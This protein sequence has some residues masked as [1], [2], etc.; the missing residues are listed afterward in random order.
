[1]LLTLAVS[2]FGSRALA[3]TQPP[4]V[5]AQLTSITVADQ[6]NE[7]RLTFSPLT[8][9]YSVVK[10]NST[11]TALGFALSSRATSTSLPRH[12]AG[13]L[14]SMSIEQQDT[15]LIVRFF[16]DDAIKL[17]PVSAGQNTVVV[18]FQSITGAPR[19]AVVASVAAPPP[20]Q[21]YIE[22]K[23]GEDDFEVVPLRYADVSEVVGLITS[24]ASIKPNDS[25]TPREPDFGSAG[26]GG[27]ATYV[28]AAP[29]TDQNADIPLGESVND[30]I[31]VDRRLNA[32]ILRG[33][34]AT[35]ARLKAQIALIDV[36]VQSVILETTFV[37]L[38]ETGARN[39]GL[40]FNNANNQVGV[41]TF[42]AG[43]FLPPG[44]PNSINLSST[45]FQ[46]ALYAQ[47]TKG[48]GKIV[49]KPRIAAQSGSSAKIITGDALPI[50]TSI[51]LSGVNGV[52]Q[53]VQYVNVGV[54]LQIAPRVADN[55]F[56]TS[57]VF[58]VVSSV[59]G[60]SQGYPTISQRKAETSA[61]VADGETF[62]IGGLSEENELKTNNSIPVLGDI[63]LLG[64]LFD[65]NKSTDSKTELYIVVT[66]HIVH[67]SAAAFVPS[68]VSM[69][70]N[71][72]SAASAAPH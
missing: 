41:A 56:V 35:I 24:G 66:P 45:A 19:D 47:V 21:P 48:N 39:V 57:H 4:P 61:T 67:G 44:F 6:G 63:P 58:C 62:V 26:L 37:E 52:Q 25:F 27:T 10:N 11:A 17:V 31:A 29:L 15:V 23:P 2:A 36:P 5:P 65:L 59:T 51:A 38:T 50:L 28:P 70:L 18:A 68:A 3:Q 49:S 43:Q 72:T 69:N 53:Q 20:V 64:R 9:S 54:T 42:Q 13:H 40:D 30:A 7:V 46:A 22:P 55:G 1:L 8:P 12:Y 60:F 34:P 32:I 16:T 71:P 14:K 33:S